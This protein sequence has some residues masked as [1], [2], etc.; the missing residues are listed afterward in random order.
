[1]E[2]LSVIVVVAFIILL[3][4]FLL[5]N[6]NV[7]LAAFIILF[8]CVMVGIVIEAV[9]LRNKTLTKVAANYEKV[10]TGIKKANVGDT[11][12]IINSDKSQTKLIVIK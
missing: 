11:V 5:A 2:I 7:A 12:V 9:E 8:V 10:K 1:M 4:G 6:D 3:I